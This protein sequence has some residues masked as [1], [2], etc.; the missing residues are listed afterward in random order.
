MNNK[1]KLCAMFLASLLVVSIGTAV[2]SSPVVD[3]GDGQID[4]IGS[5]T[6]VNITLNE[7]P[8]GLSGYNLTVSLSKPSIAEIIS[9]SYPSWAT[10]HDNSA[11]PADS[12]W[13]KA[14]DL[15]E[16]VESGA[17]NINLGALTFRGDEEGTSDILITVTKMDD[18][19][20]YPI[21][22][23]IDPGHLRVGEAECEGTD[24]SCG[25]YPNC[26]NCTEK[27]G[28]YPYGNGCE[29]RAYYCK[30]N[31]EGCDY[32]YSNRHTDEWVDTGNTRWVDDPENECK[33]KKQ[34]EQ[35]YRN[36]NCSDGTCTY[37]VTDTQWLDTGNTWNK[38]D[39]TI[40]GCTVNNTLKTCYDGNCTDTGICNSTNCSADAVCDGKKP[41]ESCGAGRLCNSTCRC[42]R[43]AP[44]EIIFY[45]PDS[46][47]HD[48]RG[49]TRTFNIT[50]NQTV[51]VSW[52]INGTT[53]QTNGSVTEASYTNTSA[54]IGTWN[55]SAIVTNANGTD[56]QMWAWTVTS[57]CFIATAA[58]GTPL[59]DDIN[60]LRDFRDKYL[61]SNSAG[62]A[63]VMT[64]YT[65]SPP[66]ADVIRANEGLMA[67]VRAGL[68]K[69][70]VHITG[71]FVG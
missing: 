65:L 41:G 39:G 26:E 17:T 58:Y 4:T 25:I 12:I 29:E 52:Q 7:A 50:I 16:Q 37:S 56:M 23:S 5:T 33:E 2:A 32:T 62:R 44:P 66:V 60:V 20:G 8:N 6:T 27:D 43:L 67:L 21:N 31:E 11:L 14:A 36:Y 19:N 71:M 59:H 48:S 57:P 55:I 42:V 30:S 35:E 45:V 1:N 46:P 18:D 22:P 9:V 64:Y 61:M 54:V 24:T 10:L 38:P 13:M 40:C 15:L 34:K 70:L 49:A 68:V 47:V 69:P 3:V 63:F 28:C 51:I 53:V